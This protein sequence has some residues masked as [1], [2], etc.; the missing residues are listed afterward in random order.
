MG[1]LAIVAIPREDDYVHKISSEK[2]PHCTL[3]FLGDSEGKS[4]ARIANFVEHAVGICA[5]GPFGLTVDHRGELGPDKADVLF[6]KKSW[7]SRRL[8]E[9]RGQLLQNNEIRDAYDSVTQY[10]EFTPHL[11]L[12]YPRTPAREDKRDYP[13]F[14][15]IE[16]DRI[17]VW[18]GNYEGPEFRLE[19]DYNDDLAEVAMS[20]PAERGREFLEHYGVKGMKWGVRR[21]TTPVSVT[22]KIAVGPRGKTK[23]KGKGGHAQEATPDAI[24][25]AT[26]KQ[27]HKKSGAAALSNQE[28][29]DLATRMQLEQQ[30]KSLDAQSKSSGKKLVKSLVK[31][32]GNQGLGAVRRA[33]KKA[34]AKKI[35]TGVAVAG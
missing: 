26:L 13:G 11:T 6:F 24:K 20:Q 2:V 18:T 5:I 12:G 30:V 28:L 3:L 19:Y 21:S 32:E 7:A 8:E 27:K 22:T 15:W 1:N 4:A 16:F 10:P 35:A 14:H 9:F 33:G 31:E 34:A 29:R 25:A 23:I 17:A